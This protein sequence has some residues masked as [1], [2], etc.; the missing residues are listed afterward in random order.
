MNLP[1]LATEDT[2]RAFHSH[3]ALLAVLGTL[4]CTLAGGAHMQSP[5]ESMRSLGTGTAHH[6][7]ISTNSGSRWMLPQELS[8]T[9]IDPIQDLR[10]AFVGTSLLRLSYDNIVDS[11]FSPAAS[12]M[13]S[14]QT[15]APDLSLSDWADAFG[16]SKQTISNWASS[17]PRGRP[18]LDEA[19]AAL[20]VASRRHSDL[21]SWLISPLPGNTTTPT[22]LMRSGS[23]RAFRAASRLRSAIGDGTDPTEAM[24][25]EARVR[26]AISKRLGGPDAPA[27]ENREV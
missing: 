13:A 23:W 17:D 27:S 14:L 9:A 20:S 26:R 19:V 1:L 5:A 7:L 16:V 25:T 8:S 11:P 15:M 3:P 10:P 6:L 24:R 21:S 4:P 18:E 2:S 22:D 12:R